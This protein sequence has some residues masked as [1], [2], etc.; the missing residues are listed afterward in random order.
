MVRLK[1]CLNILSVYNP[2]SNLA[3]GLDNSQN[4]A[5]AGIWEEKLN[6]LNREYL[7]CINARVAPSTKQQQQPDEEEEQNQAKTIASKAIDSKSNDQPQIVSNEVE[8]EDARAQGYGMLSSQFPDIDDDSDNDDEDAFPD[9]GYAQFQGNLDSEEE[10]EGVEL[11]GTEAETLETKENNGNA[12]DTT[13]QIL[14][15]DK[16]SKIQS[17]MGELDLPAPEWA[18]NVPEDV[19]MKTL[20]SGAQTDQRKESK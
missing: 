3:G 15:N 16:A 14:S 11:E 4:K 17:I 5:I 7:E 1:L 18:K 6:S 10:D 19:W 13:T 2:K 9:T 20:L 12:A 8:D